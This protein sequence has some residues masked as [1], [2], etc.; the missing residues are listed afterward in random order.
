MKSTA[1]FA[2]EKPERMRISNAQQIT[3]T[4][5]ITALNAY[6]KVVKD[7]L[8]AEFKTNYTHLIDN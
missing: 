4:T 2:P 1:L 6:I 3:V 5:K 8:V 7:A